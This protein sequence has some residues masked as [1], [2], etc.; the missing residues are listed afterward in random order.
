MFMIECTSI[1]TLQ[2]FSAVESI[3]PLTSSSLRPVFV[4]LAASH[5]PVAFSLTGVAKFSQI[6][7]TRSKSGA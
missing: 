7:L 6:Q 1:C 2:V 5:R 3:H 4:Q